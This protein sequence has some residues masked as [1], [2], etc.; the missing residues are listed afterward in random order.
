MWL[1]ALLVPC[2]GFS[3]SCYDMAEF[4][5]P[6]G[7]YLSIPY[8]TW[9]SYVTWTFYIGSMPYSNLT[10]SIVARSATQHFNLATSISGKVYHILHPGCPKNLKSATWC[11]YH[12]LSFSHRYGLY[13]KWAE[14]KWAATLLV[15]SQIKARRGGKKPKQ[16][17]LQSQRQQLLQSYLRSRDSKIEVVEFNFT[18]AQNCQLIENPR[19]HICNSFQTFQT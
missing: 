11:R 14:Y 16:N 3:A 7:A 10:T 6:E 17:R 15:C 19:R 4:R 1:L 18:V 13:L 8:R 5:S 12:C 2:T 9:R